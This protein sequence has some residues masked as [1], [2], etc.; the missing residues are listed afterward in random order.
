[1]LCCFSKKTLRH[2]ALTAVCLAS[3]SASVNVNA[4]NKKTKYFR[5]FFIPLERVLQS[6]AENLFEWETR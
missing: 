2:F 3:H 6:F 4:K 5:H 1:L